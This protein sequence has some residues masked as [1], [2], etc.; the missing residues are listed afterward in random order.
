M[1]FRRPSADQIDWLWKVIYSK[2]IILIYFEK[3][4]SARPW[5]FLTSELLSNFFDRGRLIFIYKICLK[6]KSKRF[7]EVIVIS[8]S[9]GETILIC[10][11]ACALF[12]FY[13]LNL[14]QMIEPLRFF[15]C[16]A[17]LKRAGFVQTFIQYKMHR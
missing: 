15:I 13:T 16:V 8:D 2:N 9:I 11:P 7:L 4:V 3:F 12:I 14:T 17:Q 5:I 6:F 1:L 10:P